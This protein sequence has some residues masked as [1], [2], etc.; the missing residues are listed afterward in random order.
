MGS[1]K[2]CGTMGT[3]VT[4]RPGSVDYYCPLCRARKQRKPGR[5]R[6]RSRGVYEDGGVFDDDGMI[7]DSGGGE[8]ENALE[9]MF[10]TRG[11]LDD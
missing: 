8:V 5:A 9:S 1:C 3:A 11:G 4:R 7:E 10:D 2:T 6:R